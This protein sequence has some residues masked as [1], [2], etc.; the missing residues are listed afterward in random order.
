MENNQQ[1][2]FTEVLRDLI[3]YARENENHI[4]EEEL[5]ERLTPLNMNETQLEQVKA[6]LKEQH[7]GIGEGAD[8]KAE[9]TQ[10][11]HQ[12]LNDYLEE[13]KDLPE[14]TDGQKRAYA[15]SAMAGDADAQ[16][17]LIEVYLPMVAD[18]AKL[19][20]DQGVYLEDLVGE[21]NAALVQ[22]VTLL[23]A[24]EDPGEVEMALGKQVMDA[25]EGL[26]TETVRDSGADQKIVALVQEVADKAADLAREMRRS[27]TVAELVEL[28]G[29]E[30][31][32][33]MD[34]IR[35]TGNKIEDI[36]YKEE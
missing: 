17:H 4:S 22:G 28:A 7:V 1:A 13:L 21:G 16:Q 23:G 25:M 3:R 32:K 14:Y 2:Q 31:S 19:Y 12:Y 20:A 15:M 9:L 33:I 8:V 6:Y 29:V 34:A 27:V 5:K 26:I 10:E 35:Y 18:I 30:E 36:D 11:E 24:L